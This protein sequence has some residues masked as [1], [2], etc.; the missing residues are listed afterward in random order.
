MVLDDRYEEAITVL[1]ICKHCGTEYTTNDYYAQCTTCKIFAK[2]Q[3]ALEECEIC[4]ADIGYVL[5]Y[6]LIDGV[7]IM[8]CI[9]CFKHTRQEL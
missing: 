8:I 7:P 2:H 3:P 1:Y 9:P 6:G 4:G 5:N